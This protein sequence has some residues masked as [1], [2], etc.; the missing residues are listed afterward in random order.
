[1]SIL[2][3]GR[4]N[5]RISPRKKIH[6]LLSDKYASREKFPIEDRKKA[7]EKRRF[8]TKDRKKAKK[9]IPN[10]RSEES[11]RKEK[12]KEIPCQDW[13]KTRK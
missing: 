8:L 2:A 12:E 3:L 7:K 11:K 4:R 5:R 9:E 13:K 10:Q 6:S 1:M